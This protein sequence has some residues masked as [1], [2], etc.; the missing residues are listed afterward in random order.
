MYFQESIAKEAFLHGDHVLCHE[1]SCDT[2]INFGNRRVSIRK[3]FPRS[4]LIKASEITDRIEK[5]NFLNISENSRDSKMPSRLN[6]TENLYSI[7]SQLTK[8]VTT[9]NISNLCIN[10]LQNDPLTPMDV[11]M[12]AVIVGVVVGILVGILIVSIVLLIVL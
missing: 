7:P 3:R 11:I 5:N 8:S 1:L 9:N 12:M 4:D 10:F 2:E 6:L